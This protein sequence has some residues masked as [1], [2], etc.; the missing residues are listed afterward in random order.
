MRCL[1]LGATGYIGTRLVPRL[2]IEGHEVRCLVRDPERVPASGWPPDVEILIGDVSD[3]DLVE[4][5]CA[6]TEALYYLVHEMD[7]PGFADRDRCAAT[8]VAAATR[9]RAVARIIYLSGLQP[10]DGEPVSEHLS[11]RREV[12]DILLASGIPAAVLQ[13][14][15]VLGSGSAGFEMI[16]HLAESL[17]IIPTPARAN[18]LVQP[19]AIDEALDYLVGTLR[20]PAGLNRTF[21]IGGP[22]VVSYRELSAR[23][24]C[25]AGL[26][27]HLTVPVPV[28]PRRRLFTSLAAR[29]IEALTPVSRHLAEPLL[30][31]M[32]HDLVCQETDLADLLGRSVP[33]AVSLDETLRRAI[34]QVGAAAAAPN[35]AAGSGPTVLQSAHILDA[36]APADRVWQTI[37]AM[38]GGRGWNTLPGLWPA[39]AWLDG[40]VGGVGNRSVRPDQLLPGAPWDT[41]RIET[42]EPGVSVVLRSEMRLPGTALLTMSVTAVDEAT[43]RYEQRVSFTPSGLFGRAYWYAQLPAHQLVFGVMAG[44]LVWRAESSPGV[45]TRT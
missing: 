27:T 3:Q 28:A 10:A 41:W 11:S 24:A 22:D 33:A 34:D 23:Y 44:A 45:M 5:A 42:V 2:L 32:S 4:R 43:S 36:A 6:G 9:R 29:G 17:P 38:G 21:D 37:S 1:V 39:R 13:A 12:G 16:R 14:G 18:R 20:L 19:I 15:L 7:G 25:A 31:S 35:D 40:V 8:V 26:A 30:E